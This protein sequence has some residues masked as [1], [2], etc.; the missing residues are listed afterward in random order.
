MENPVPQYLISPG[1]PGDVPIGVSFFFRNYAAPSFET[2]QVG[3]STTTRDIAAFTWGEEITYEDTAWRLYED[4]FPTGTQYVAVKYVSNKYRLFLDDFEFV[5]YSSYEKP[6]GLSV[7]GMTDQRATLTWTA[8]EGASKYAYQYR[9]VDA[10]DWLPEETVTGTSVTLENLSANTSYD[11]RIKALFGN[12]A[13]NYVTLR[14]MTEGPME[15]LPHY[16]DF[17]SGMG[18]WRLEDGYQR[19]GI[20]TREHHGGSYSFEFDEGSPHAQYLR[21][22]LLEGNSQKIVSFYYRIFTNEGS[23]QDIVGYSSAFQVGWSTK[24]SD[25]SD[26]V[27]AP[28]VRADNGSWNRYSLQVPEGVKYVFIKVKDHEAWLYVDDISITEVPGPVARAATVMGETRYATTFY[29]GARKW[30]LPKGALAYTVGKEGAEYVFYCID[31]IIPAGT[32]VI[33]LMDKT[34]EDTEDTKE[35]KL[36]LTADSGKAPY[37]YNILKGTD[38]AVDVSGGKIDDKVVYVLGI[39]N[40]KL[41]F[42]Q[43]SGTTIP[44]GKAY[45]LGD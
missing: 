24:T 41:G 18:G 4:H 26:F 31:D 11:F 8:P 3:Y 35:L 21:S 2:F 20:S 45:Y 22:P 40:G 27:E 28:E 37:P 29:D 15:T 13:S 32:P 10:G 12:N 39:R 9:Q 16:Q 43:F 30:R 38:V 6:T 25:L 34:K 36:S 1:L 5:A 33:I 7:S 23:G 42:Y 17:E 14:F 19:S 44:A